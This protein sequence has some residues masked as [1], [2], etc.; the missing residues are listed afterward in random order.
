MNHKNIHKKGRICIFQY[1]GR[2]NRQTLFLNGKL[3]IG[4]EK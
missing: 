4:A 3:E 2:A 1:S